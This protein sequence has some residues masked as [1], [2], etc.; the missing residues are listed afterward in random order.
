MYT[1]SASGM[2]AHAPYSQFVEKYRAPEQS[3]VAN[4]KLLP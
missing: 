3:E 1:G 2:S 4:V